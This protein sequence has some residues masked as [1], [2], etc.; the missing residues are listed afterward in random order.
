MSLMVKAS[1]LGKYEQVKEIRRFLVDQDVCSSFEKL[2]RQTAAVFSKLK[3][4]SFSLFYKDEDGDLVAFSSDDE[5]MMGL[6]CRKDSTFRLFI[7][8]K[9][10]HH[11]DFA[12]HDLLPY[13]FGRAEPHAP[14]HAL[15]YVPPNTSPE[16]P[17]IAL[18]HAP[19]IP[20]VTPSP[21]V[22]PPCGLPRQPMPPAPIVPQVY[23]PPNTSLD[24]PTIALPHAPSIPSVTPPPL[25]PPPSGLPFQTPSG[26]QSLTPHPGIRCDGCKGDIIGE[27]Y[28]CS[29]CPDYDLCSTCKDEEKHSQHVLLLIEEPLKEL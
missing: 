4:S 20:S 14:R 16:P 11:R 18:P 7:K 17:T 26:Y 23:G 12:L 22:P 13:L 10:E 5:L 19:S 27:R 1:L 3:N 21:P 8:E 29:T 6:G 2:S 28:K 15:V 24:P 9:K 25:V